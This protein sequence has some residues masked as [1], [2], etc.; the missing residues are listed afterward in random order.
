ME[1][2]QATL[3]DVAS[4]RSMYACYAVELQKFDHEPP[5]PETV[6]EL[7]LKNAI[8]RHCPVFLAV[9]DDAVV[10]MVALITAGDKWLTNLCVYVVPQNRRNGIATDLMLA[11]RE[12]ARKRGDTLVWDTV[13]LDNENAI[14]LMQSLGLK[15]VA[16]AYTYSP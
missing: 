7:H 9:I 10:G 16:Y 3:E 15:P 13:S 11:A 5:K 4:I 8:E 2:R 14:R 6:W 1:I 12:N